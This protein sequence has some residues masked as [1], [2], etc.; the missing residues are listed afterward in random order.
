[1]LEYELGHV[2]AIA[3]VIEKFERRD[4][5]E[6]LGA[7]LRVPLEH[8]GHRELVRAVLRPRGR[9]RRARRRARAARRGGGADAA[10]PRAGQRGRRAVEHRGRGLG[11]AAGR[12]ARLAPPREGGGREGAS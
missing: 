4:V 7:A 1:M 11:V 12:R 10:L 2:Q 8:A 6:V 9:A 3:A 5:A